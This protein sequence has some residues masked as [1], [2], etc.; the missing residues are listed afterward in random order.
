M[1]VQTVYQ[2]PVVVSDRHH[3]VSEKSCRCSLVNTIGRELAEI[4][5]IPR[6]QLTR[7]VECAQ[8][9]E[10][11]TRAFAKR[12]VCEVDGKACVHGLR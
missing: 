5:E 12:T 2:F 11:L 4:T 9:L 3:R 6:K 10:S 7:R 8:K 1:A